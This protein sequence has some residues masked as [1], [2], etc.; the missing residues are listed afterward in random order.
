MAKTPCETEVFVAGGGPAGLAAAIAARQA[1]FEV[2]LV[3]CA[4]APIDKACGEGIMP[5]GLAALRQLGIAIGPATAVPFR[6]I[7]FLDDHNQVQAEFSDGV[8]YGI[9]RTSLHAA[10]TERAK[11][12][13]VRLFWGTRVTGLADSTIHLEDERVRYRW[14]ICA[15]GHNS[16]L[17]RCTGLD[18]SRQSSRRCGFR[19]HYKLTSWTDHVEVHWSDCGQMYVTPI[20]AQEVCV[21]LIARDPHLRF[22]EAFSHFPAMATRLAGLT[23]ERDYLGA[24]T[25]TRRFAAVQSRNIALVGEA[26]GSIDAVTGE[27]LSLAFR[28][29]LALADALKA[30]DLKQYE[31]AH[32]KLS[33][34]PRFMSCLMLS[35]DRYPALRRR[36][37]QAFAADPECF[38]RMLAMHTGAI[39]AA[40]FGVW[41]GLTLGWNLLAGQEIQGAS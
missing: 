35:M 9:R 23:P 41:H 10:M 36:A 40:D 16:R 11:Q 29:A 15:D 2:T 20:S 21:A 12:V 8:G 18:R 24:I 13:G 4:Q 30:N 37:L 39:T 33:R 27:G 22:D 17:R 38:Q 1:G 14:L 19:R 3:D 7:R 34:L 5:D 26:S 6:G 25:G 32:R 28:Q 31:T